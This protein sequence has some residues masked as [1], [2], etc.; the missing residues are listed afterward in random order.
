MSPPEHASYLPDGKPA[1]RRRVASGARLDSTSS[2]RRPP[3]STSASTPVRASPANS[4][5]QGFPPPPSSATPSRRFPR[6]PVT[7]P[8]SPTILLELPSTADACA[9]RRST[10]PPPHEP[11]ALS[12]AHP[13]L[14]S[15]TARPRRPRCAHPLHE[16]HTP[17]ICFFG[18]HPAHPRAPCRCEAPGMPVRCSSS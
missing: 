7:H 18:V 4:T 13:G 6:V 2:P 8:S 12:L 17:S 9:A 15:I 11:H 5:H 14:V 16:S 3:S 1:G 10:I